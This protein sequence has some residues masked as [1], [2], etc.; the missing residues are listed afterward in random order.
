MNTNRTDR[1]S[2]KQT[3]DCTRRGWDRKSCGYGVRR[4]RTH[5]GKVSPDALAVQYA[6]EAVNRGLDMTLAEGLYL[7]ATLFA[8]CCSTEH[9]NEGTRA[10]LEKRPTQFW[11]KIE[12]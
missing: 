8:V 12:L 10:F 3:A 11:G 4:N 9:K 5:P 2:A 6:M 1:L 7:E